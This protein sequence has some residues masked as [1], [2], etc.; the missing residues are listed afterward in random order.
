[1]AESKT[2]T[3]DNEFTGMAQLVL[4]LFSY[5]PLFALIIMPVRDKNSRFIT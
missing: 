3:R 4:F 1:M 2:R 5:L